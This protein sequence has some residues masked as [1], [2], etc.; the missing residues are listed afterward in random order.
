MIDSILSLQMNEQEKDACKFL[1]Q[2]LYDPRRLKEEDFKFLWD[3]KEKKMTGLIMMMIRMQLEYSKQEGRFTQLA[4]NVPSC[5]LYFSIGD[6][7]ES[8][9]D[10]SVYKTNN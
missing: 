3:N 4:N 6:Q 5:Y 2:L 10:L 1:V 8:T 9:Q 7:Y